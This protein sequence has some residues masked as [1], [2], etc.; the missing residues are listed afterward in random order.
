M[1]EKQLNE[2]LGISKSLNIHTASLDTFF[3]FTIRGTLFFLLYFI[4]KLYR[5]IFNH[6]YFYCQQFIKD[7]CI[8]IFSFFHSN[9]N[10]S[11]ICIYTHIYTNMCLYSIQFFSIQ[12]VILLSC[13][14]LPLGLV[15][16]VCYYESGFISFF[17][18]PLISLFHTNF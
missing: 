14:F 4:F 5:F 16:L 11:Y 6:S 7:I 15:F 2:N 18:T 17:E 12:F 3:F 10:S 13:T 9:L 1:N 8:C